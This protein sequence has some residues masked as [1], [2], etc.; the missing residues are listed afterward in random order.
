MNFIRRLSNIDSNL[1]NEEKWRE[2]WWSFKL[3]IKIDLLLALFLA[4]VVFFKINERSALDSNNPFF[5]GDNNS[6][7]YN[8]ALLI[9]AASIEEIIFRLHIDFKRSHILISLLAAFFLL[10][11]KV[12]FVWLLV[13]G[14]L[15]I[16][17]ITSYHKSFELSQNSQFLN[18]YILV[19][20]F[21]F[22]LAHTDDFSNINKTNCIV[23]ILLLLNRMISG[24]LLSRIRL[25]NGGLEWSIGLHV[26]LN[27]I[28][29]IIA[30]IR[31]IK[32]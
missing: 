21:I 2:L 6:F 28:P 18:I 27:S 11:L 26:M 17:D 1:S 9:I 19:N 13:I 23:F 5:D 29:F 8:F 24:I 20:S 22:T 7:G 15:L 3:S 30:F 32:N 25:K 12:D 14:N 16:L 10:F 4:L 31:T